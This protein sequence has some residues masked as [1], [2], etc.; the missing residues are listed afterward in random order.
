[1]QGS[2]GTEVPGR[3]AKSK[4]R[5]RPR[6]K[7]VD[8]RARE[9]R[10][11]ADRQ[12]DMDREVEDMPYKRPTSLD[13]PEPRPGM[14]QRWVDVGVEGHW[15]EK[16]WARRSREG[17]VP[18]SSSTVPK[19]FPVPKVGHGRFAGCIGVEGMILCEMTLKQAAKRREYYASKTKLVRKKIDADLRAANA[20]AG[21]GFGPIK[22][23]EVS[24]LVRER[25]EQPASEEVEL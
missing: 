2:A 10:A 11:Q 25:N 14:K 19:S 16:N 20:G 22:K 17:W 3:V 7:Q 4:Q 18:R 15:N 6:A 23:A 12:A 21:G 5:G 13:A 8:D 1:M 24:K 9:S